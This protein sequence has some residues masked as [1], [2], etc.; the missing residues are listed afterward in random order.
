MA[1]VTRRANPSWAGNSGIPEFPLVELDDGVCVVVEPWVVVL[2]VVDEEVELDD[3]VMVVT[4]D[5]IR[6]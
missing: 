4:D 5:S 6:A 3:V 2:A 1:T